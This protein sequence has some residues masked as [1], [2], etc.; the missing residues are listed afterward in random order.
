MEISRLTGAQHL[1][2]LV[3][4][5]EGAGDSG[6]LTALTGFS[7]SS[8]SYAVFFDRSVAFYDCGTEQF[9]DLA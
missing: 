7:A 6:S 3:L 8:G 1:Q 2:L 4:N 9:A 5:S